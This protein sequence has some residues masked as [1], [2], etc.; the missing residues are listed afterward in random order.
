MNL[1][2]E[3]SDW[4]AAGQAATALVTSAVTHP[5]PTGGALEEATALLRGL[6]PCEMALSIVW[7][8]RLAGDATLRA[9]G[10][11][12]ERALEELQ[13]LGA[14][15]VHSAVEGAQVADALD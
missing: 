12:E 1:T 2:E 9:N 11:S 13:A 7:L 15:L 5:D 6:T 8:A 10:G 3:C 4:I 14:K